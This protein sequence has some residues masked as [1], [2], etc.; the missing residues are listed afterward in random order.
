MGDSGLMRMA[1]IILAVMVVIGAVSWVA[2]LDDWDGADDGKRAKAAAGAAPSS[3]EAACRLE[4]ASHPLPEEVHEASG[5]ALSRRAEGLL[6]THSDAGEPLIVAVDADGNPRGMVR[7]TGASMDNWE[8][9]ASG[10]CAS[11][12]CLF[13]AD[14]GDNA[15]NRAHVTV[16]RVAEPEPAAAGTAAVEALHATYPDGAHDAEAMFV[17]SA[18]RIYLVTKGENGPV[19]VYRYPA[20]PAADSTVQLERVL[21]LAEGQ[22]R[23]S[24]RITGAS[25]SRDG[26]WVALRSLGSVALYPLG[27][28]T[29][30][31]SLRRP[32]RF[33]VDS[34]R[35]PQGE[36]IALDTGGVVYLAS[37]GG[38]KR[39]PALLSRMSCP[40]AGL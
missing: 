3:D 14:I 27:A 17:D 12:D 16:Y 22:L 20:A 2:G 25:A 19:A 33:S 21:S 9:I 15:A 23:R 1:A 26:R 29:G 31:D 13:I 11:G 4:G 18:G 8:D 35:E 34:A 37:E 10:P 39:D 32:A 7:V 24:E 6:W 5:L 30:E 38:R 28:L 40:V 36:G